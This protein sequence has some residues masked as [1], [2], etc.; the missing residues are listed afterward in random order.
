MNVVTSLFSPVR[1]K[2]RRKRP[3][4]SPKALQGQ[5]YDR[6]TFAVFAKV[7]KR[8]S[9]C[10]D[11]GAHKGSIHKEMIRQSPRSFCALDFSSQSAP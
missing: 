6:Q 7:L 10:L 1:N 8:D 11:I 2:L 3:P 5:E 4:L 9:C